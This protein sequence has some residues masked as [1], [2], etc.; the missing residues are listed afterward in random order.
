MSLERYLRHW[1]RQ[2]AR[3][4][5]PVPLQKDRGPSH[6]QLVRRGRRVRQTVCL[7]MGTLTLLSNQFKA[8]KRRA[9]RHR[10]LPY[11]RE[12]FTEAVQSNFRIGMAD[13][14]NT[15]GID[16]RFTP[17]KPWFRCLNA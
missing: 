11:N 17:P 7:G 3:S 13:A 15:L 8:D 14:A 9:R 12:A 6:A 5:T 2:P 10:V 1:V 4:V 16:L